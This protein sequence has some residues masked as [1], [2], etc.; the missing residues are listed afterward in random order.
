MAST[1]TR[2]FLENRARPWGG[3]G[4]I[5]S[6]LVLGLPKL[7][8]MALRIDRPSETPV[9]LVA[10]LVGHRHAIFPQLRQQSLQIP[11]AKIHHELRLTGPEIF[12]VR[13][14]DRPLRRAHRIR[15]ILCAPLEGMKSRRLLA[16]SRWYER[17][18]Q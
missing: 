9:A 7:D 6:S 3:P 10:D 16:F 11:H 1:L 5:S 8:P 18:S 12:G 13:R 2:K 15:M 17:D 4:S 14:K